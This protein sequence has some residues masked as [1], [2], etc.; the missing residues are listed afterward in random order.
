M[1]VLNRI[2]TRTGDAGDTARTGTG[3][4]MED[5]SVIGWQSGATLAIYLHGLFENTSVMTALFQ[6][7]GRSLDDAFDRLADGIDHH[8]RRET[9]MRLIGR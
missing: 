3:A 1:V 9:L 4:G 6:T 2:Y 7:P 8:I 5:R